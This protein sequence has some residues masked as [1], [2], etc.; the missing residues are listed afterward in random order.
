MLSSKYSVEDKMRPLLLDW[1]ANL[2]LDVTFECSDSYQKVITAHG[3]GSDLQGEPWALFVHCSGSPPPP[4]DDKQCI[5]NKESV[6]HLKIDTLATAREARL[7]HCDSIA[8][9]AG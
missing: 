1:L 4:E 3:I 6:F 8:L 9:P 7:R 5:P 2:H